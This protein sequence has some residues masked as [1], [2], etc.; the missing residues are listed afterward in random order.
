LKLT[1]GTPAL[2]RH[3]KDS[4]RK[5]KPFDGV[6]KVFNRGAVALK[7]RYGTP[8]R[9]QKRSTA[10]NTKQAKGERRLTTASG[11][12]RIRHREQAFNA[13]PSTFPRSGPPGST[14]KIF[15][16][17]RDTRTRDLQ[18]ELDIFEATYIIIQDE[19]S[20]SNSKNKL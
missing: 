11:E 3:A 9:P 14:P 4:R 15:A 17:V 20:S 19:Q 1:G 5:T 16:T 13:Q 2:L 10:K 7:Q 8:E 6:T 18:L 12:L